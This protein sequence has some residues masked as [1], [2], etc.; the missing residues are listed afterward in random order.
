MS[1]KLSYLIKH[2]LKVPIEVTPKVELF[3]YI[4]DNT[5]DFSS[6]R[7]VKN[8]STTTIAEELKII[9][10]PSVVGE[11]KIWWNHKEEVLATKHEWNKNMLQF[12]SIS[13]HNLIW[14]NMLLKVS[15]QHSGFCGVC[16]LLKDLGHFS[17]QS[18]H[19]KR[20][21]FFPPCLCLIPGCMQQH[22]V[23]CTEANVLVCTGPVI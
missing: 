23:S 3:P 1:S 17:Y 16:H 11:I 9:A 7:S 19:W 10:L 5:W 6:F 14:S 13:A 22:M 2:T 21:S 15:Y 18:A 4:L 8:I 12:R 20:I